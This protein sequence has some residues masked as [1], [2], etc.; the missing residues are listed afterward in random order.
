MAM[1]KKIEKK[2]HR[3]QHGQRLSALWLCFLMF[4]FGYLAASWFDV[5]QFGNWVGNQF[6]SHSVTEPASAKKSMVEK[7]TV[8]R[9]PKLE[10]YTL[11]SS[12]S[13][14]HINPAAST[15]TATVNMQYKAVPDKVHHSLP[16][17]AAP[18]SGPMELAI[19]TPA[20][21]PVTASV[22]TPKPLQ[23][24]P[25][26]KSAPK[27]APKPAFTT[28]FEPTRMENTKGNYVMQVG[29][30][31]ILVDAKHLRDKLA[32]RGFTANITPVSHLSTYRVMV[33]PFS[34]YMQAQ[35]AQSSIANREHITGMIRKNDR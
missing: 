29:S 20:S 24:I 14:L 9:H 5:N 30:F 19:T 11:L 33:G 4:V 35:Q 1:A 26:Q 23:V 16:N 6:K 13:G 32:A 18:A 2:P 15:E 31:R 28:A 21:E 27:L 12:D 22:Q 10:F 25:T 34:S 3:S 8:E 7:P 17:V